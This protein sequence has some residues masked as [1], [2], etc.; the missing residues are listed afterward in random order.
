M[1]TFD[2][3]TGNLADG[4]H[5]GPRF[6][7]RHVS[8][9]LGRKHHRVTLGNAGQAMIR[10]RASDAQT[11]IDIFRRG[12]YDISRLQQ[13][14]DVLAAY[15]ALVRAGR[16]P[17]IVDA[18]ANVGAASIWFGETFPE[19]RI[20]AVE[21][22]EGNAEVLRMNVRQRGNIEVVEAAIDSRLGRVSLQADDCHAWAVQVERD[23]GGSIAT[24]TIPK[25][26]EAHDAG[27]L[28]LVKVDIE[29]FEAQLFED[30]LAWLDDVRVVM[31]E[32]HDWLLPGAGTSRNFQ[33]AMLERRFEMVISGENLVYIRV[34]S[35]PR[36]RP[37]M[38]GD[39]DASSIPVALTAR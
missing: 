4:V 18:G 8:R 12:A 37:A 32:P 17:V 9:V 29:G 25:I 6:P 30:N 26:M 24:T 1:S 39:H 34:Q 38:P 5:F 10:P 27:D 31:I 28:F 35:R 11:F 23:A 13:Y 2:K 7:L 16:S 21:P 20:Y 3:I 19:A 36:A 14:G 22:D 33:R 15:D